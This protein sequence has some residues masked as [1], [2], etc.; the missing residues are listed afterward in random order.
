M[1][2]I[3]KNTVISK[4]HLTPCIPLYLITKDCQIYHDRDGS[5]VFP[6]DPFW[7]FYWPGGQAVSKYILEHPEL[8]QDKTVLDLGSGCGASAIAAIKKGARRVIANDID[9]GT[10]NL[11]EIFH[12]SALFINL[13]IIYK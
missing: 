5:K 6:E 3:R 2:K 9:E 4:D 7:G 10:N 11:F 13:L 12:E 8:V 1:E